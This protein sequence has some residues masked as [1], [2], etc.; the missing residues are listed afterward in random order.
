MTAEAL[1]LVPSWRLGTL[2]AQARNRDGR[3]LADVAAHSD[4][5]D[6]A[7]LAAIERGEHP[8]DDA[9]L[10]AIVALYGIDAADLVPGRTDLVVDL[11]NHRLATAGH[12]QPLA[13]AAPTADE[14]LACYLSLV[15]TLRQA[16]P[17][18]Q[19]PL[20]QADLDVLA[21]AL[22][23]ATPDIEHRLVDLM[24]SPSPLL[25]ERS[26]F[27]RARVLVPAAG[28]LLAITVAGA[29]VVS[30]NAAEP[31]PPPAGTTVDST[32]QIDGAATQT[33]NP[34][35]TPGP[36]VVV[37][38]GTNATDLPPGAVGLGDAQVAVRNPDGSITQGTRGDEAGQPGVSTTSTP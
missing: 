7:E 26:R 8:L 29:I 23:L 2:L 30:S 38:D 4:V 36:V 14:V 19:V 13:G 33:R 5:Y 35:G 28:V 17:G 21:R 15:Y 37:G 24:A 32:V 16:E 25:R 31:P 10:E 11:D 12:T 18:S 27:L 3:T 22:A 34:D 9:A 20:R 1:A 6:E